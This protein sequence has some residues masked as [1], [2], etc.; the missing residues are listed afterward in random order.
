MMN[1]E[2]LILNV[3]K[4]RSNLKLLNKFISGDGYRIFTAED[5]GEL[6]QCLD[7]EKPELVLLDLT[8]FDQKIWKYCERMREMKI[9]F[10]I[11]SPRRSA[12][13]KQV[14]LARG[15][16]NVLTKPL[17]INQLLG[18]IRGLLEK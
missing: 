2:P 12:F 7:K 13:I 3:N 17:V 18:L 6:D 15:A 9:P 10:I 1:G 8:G 4:S 14:S 5:L 16:H 11:I